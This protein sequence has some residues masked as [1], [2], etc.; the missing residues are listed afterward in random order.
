MSIEQILDMPFEQIHLCARSIMR[1]KVS[2]IE[3]VMEPI[4]EGFGAKPS[5]SS[6][7]RRRKNS[8]PKTKEQKEKELLAKLGV[9]LGHEVPIAKQ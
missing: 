8:T 6:K 3:M 4:A 7:K 9:A 1:H 2:M 5:K